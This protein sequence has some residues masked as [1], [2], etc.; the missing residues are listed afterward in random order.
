M[1]KPIVITLIIGVFCIVVVIVFLLQKQKPQT[2]SVTQTQ[3]QP[4]EELV[5][6]ED[7]AGFSFK[8]PKTISVNKHNEDEENYA[9]I[10]LTSATHSGRL[11]VW[12]KDTTYAD[13]EAWVKNSVSVD[14]TLGGLLAKKIIISTPSKK[15]IIGTISDQILFT[16][17][18]EPTESDSYWTDVSNTIA[19][20]FAFTPT[21]TTNDSASE[22]A[23][24]DEEEVVE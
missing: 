11:I 16:I 8:Y 23:S 10:E 2:K 20:G 7:Q 19:S 1:K 18:A 9:H 17:E 22:E 21:E 3:N 5:L 6:W 13:V 15:V 14:T 12:A 24:Y 4:V